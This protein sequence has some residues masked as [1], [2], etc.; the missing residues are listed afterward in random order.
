MN[1]GDSK[2]PIVFLR[3]TVGRYL[4][5]GVHLVFLFGSRASGSAR[6]FS[7]FD[8]GVVG[9]PLPPDVRASIEQEFEDSDFPYLVDLVEF[10]DVSERFADL[11]LSAIVPI[12]FE[13]GV[14]E[15]RRAMGHTRQG[16]R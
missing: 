1:F 8:L 16:T 14:N 5:P 12:N 13:G 10:N 15:V 7:D 4:S 11:A 6:P 2:D 3:A 9:P